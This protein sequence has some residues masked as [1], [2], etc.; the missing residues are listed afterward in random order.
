MN[1]DFL[2]EETVDGAFT[3]MGKMY[4]SGPMTDVEDFN[5]A[6]FNS[7]AEEFRAAGFEVCSPAEFFD[8]D[9]TLERKDYMRESIKWLLEA[10]TVVLLPGWMASEGAKLE[11]KIATELDLI[12]VEYVADDDHREELE[13]LDM[14]AAGLDL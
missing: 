7:V 9:T 5:H 13:K 3:G 10:D 4:L 6:L 1:K 2:D 11:A 8:G 14:E 12:I